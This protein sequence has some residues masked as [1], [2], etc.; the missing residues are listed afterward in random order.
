MP[1]LSPCW[2]HHT[3][4]HLL[5]D[6]QIH[7]Q[8]QGRSRFYRKSLQQ[9]ESSW[10]R[11]RDKRKPCRTWGRL[12]TTHSTATGKE[13]GMVLLIIPSF[14]PVIYVTTSLKK[15]VLAAILI[16]SYEYSFLTIQNHPLPLSPSITYKMLV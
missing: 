9:E 14:I 12:T 10:N 5:L 4:P 3:K 15:I 13:F 7:P 1:L 2:G 8:L 11:S 6:M 16:F